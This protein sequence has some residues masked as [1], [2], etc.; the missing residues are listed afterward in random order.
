M[1]KIEP[2]G[3]QLFLDIKLLIDETKISVSKVVSSGVTALYWN[4]GKRINSEI[5]NN[6]RAEYGKQIVA[7]L[8]RQLIQEYGNSFEVKNLRR[9]IQF[10]SQ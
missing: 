9:M 8:S 3:R 6:Q 2:T 10:A 7:T 1:N 5:L 4:I